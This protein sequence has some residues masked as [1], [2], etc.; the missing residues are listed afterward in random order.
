MKLKTFFLS[1]CGVWCALA[2]GHAF[3]Q[4]NVN[5]HYGETE[6]FRRSSLCLILLTHQGTRYAEEME[7]QFL[8][9]PLPERYN[10]HNIDIRVLHT[11]GKASKGDIEYLLRKHDVAKQLVAKWFNRDEYTGHM[12][13]KLIHDRGGYNATYADRRRAESTER[14]LAT[15]PEEGVDLIQ[16]TFVLVCDMSY[17]DKA[18]TGQAF[19]TL[20]A[21]G[22]AALDVN[23]QIQR[24]QGNYESAN[25][26]QAAAQ[27][28]AAGSVVASDIGGF[29]VNMRAHL[30]RL[31]WDDKLKNT[32]Y[33]NYWVDDSTPESEARTRRAAFDSDDESFEL[34][35]LGYYRSRSA[36]TVFKSQVEL[37]QI[38]RRVC[39]NTVS[40]AMNRLAKAYPVFKPKTPFYCDGNQLYAYIGTKEGVRYGQKYEVLEQKRRKGTIQYKHVAT[41]TPTTVW[42]NIGVNY[43]TTN[44]GSSALNAASFFRHKSGRKD[45][46][47]KGYLLREQGRLGYQYKR[48]N[49]NIGFVTE[50]YELKDGD[51]YD[52]SYSSYYGD[53]TTARMY[54]LE[55]GWTVN[56]G[57]WFAWNVLQGKGLFGGDGLAAGGYTA[58]TLRTPPTRSGALSIFVQPQAGVLYRDL[59]GMDGGLVNF[60]WNVKAGINLTRF[61]YVAYTYGSYTRHGASL[62]FIF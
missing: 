48:H 26:S 59:D 39:A 12:D 25:N 27:L 54:G 60:D 56:F 44:S 1:L 7:Q 43:A 45:L 15:L 47:D 29:A 49:F 19:S 14:G 62:G 4:N 37:N 11:S 13:M 42:N 35:Y 6:T 33:R 58:I 21:L 61:L 34:E 24:Q 16:N 28:A 36:R 50:T 23:S 53:I 46:C 41:V 52:Y 30:L 31:K 55:L 57:K 9:M 18:K 5:S 40:L 10:D 38:I 32:I 51:F 17:Y 2:G 22:A 3:A 8:Q 20:L